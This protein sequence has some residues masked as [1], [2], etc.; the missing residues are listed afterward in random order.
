[1]TRRNSS[2]IGAAAI[3]VGVV[4]AWYWLGAQKTPPGQPQLTMLNAG[5]LAGLADQFNA[6]SDKTRI[7]VLLSPT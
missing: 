3:A 2:L 5:R 7:L 6:A 4:V 1:M